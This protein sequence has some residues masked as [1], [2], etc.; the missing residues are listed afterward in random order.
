MAADTHDICTP[1]WGAQRESNEFAD[2][3]T[4]EDAARARGMG[5]A[6]PELMAPE[7]AAQYLINVMWLIYG[8]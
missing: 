3:L 5:V 2:L 6:L 7:D 1:R 8:R 4:P